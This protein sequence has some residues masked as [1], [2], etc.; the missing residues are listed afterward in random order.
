MEVFPEEEDRKFYVLRRYQHEDN[1]PGLKG[2]HY[3]TYQGV[4]S[5]MS[6]EDLERYF[7][8]GTLNT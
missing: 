5:I 6:K 1:A 4:P 3:A 2:K 7:E 8:F